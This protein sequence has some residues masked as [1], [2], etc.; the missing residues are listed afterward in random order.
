M[1]RQRGFNRALPGRRRATS[2][3][4][5]VGGVAVQ[6]A[7]SASTSV[8]ATSALSILIDGITVVRHRGSALFFLN[9]ADASLSGFRGAFGIGIA[10]TPAV[11]AGAASVPMPI[12]EQD[13]EGWMYWQRIECTAAQA[14][15]GAAADD[16]DAISQV[17]AVQRF[18]FDSKA[19]RKVDEDMSIYAAL[20][21]TETGTAVLNWAL[22][23]RILVK[24]S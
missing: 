1:A 5:G 7:I 9:S 11:V 2:W 10:T 24:L 23:S 6:T 3:E 15:A 4:E 8:I 18:E 17:T 13:W 19:M 14:I 20:E 21:V 22:D 12:T 16:G